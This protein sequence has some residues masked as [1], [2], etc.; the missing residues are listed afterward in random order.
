MEATINKP[1][2]AFE[3]YDD[4]VIYPY[5]SVPF[6]EYI[7]ASDCPQL[8]HQTVVVGSLYAVYITSKVQEGVG[9]ILYVVIYQVTQ[10]QQKLHIK[11]YCI[12]VTDCCCS[13][14]DVTNTLY[15]TIHI[16]T[17]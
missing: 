5:G 8:L 14:H 12:L 2:I 9:C 13:A 7:S 3:K 17:Q 1:V 11:I 10:S 15:Y 4:I 6:N 16:A